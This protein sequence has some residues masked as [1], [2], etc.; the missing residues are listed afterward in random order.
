M[1]GSSWKDFSASTGH[2]VTKKKGQGESLENCTT[3]ILAQFLQKLLGDFWKGKELHIPGKITSERIPNT[4]CQV[5][6]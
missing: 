2:E 1:K 5:G 6:K 4:H 3:G